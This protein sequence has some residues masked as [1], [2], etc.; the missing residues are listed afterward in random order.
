MVARAMFY[1]VERTF[2][3]SIIKLDSLP[4]NRIFIVLEEL[5]SSPIPFE[6]SFY[7]DDNVASSNNGGI[8]VFLVFLYKD[9]YPFFSPYPIANRY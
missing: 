8:L 6:Y 1:I 9:T 7:R 5:H 4:R 3:I 2:S